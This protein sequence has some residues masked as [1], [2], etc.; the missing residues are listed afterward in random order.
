MKV[1]QRKIGKCGIMQ[2]WSI[3]NNLGNFVFKRLFIM[4]VHSHI[5]A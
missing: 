2:T 1:S 3:N 5:L 4:H